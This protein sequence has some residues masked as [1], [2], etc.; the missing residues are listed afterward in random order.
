M[1]D[2]NELYHFL[3]QLYGVP[4]NC[5]EMRMRTIPKILVSSKSFLL[6][7]LKLVVKSNPAQGGEL[8]NS[9]S[10]NVL[11]YHSGPR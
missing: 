9:A 1:L 6:A 4:G 5:R 8:R 11:N 3:N 7:P 2:S 10:D